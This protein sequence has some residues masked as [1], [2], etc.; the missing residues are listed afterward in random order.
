MRF[1]E[2]TQ[3]RCDMN[4][5]KQSLM[6]LLKVLENAVL[7]AQPTGQYIGLT[8]GD[9]VQIQSHA[10]IISDALE[11]CLKSQEHQNATE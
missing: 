8:A 7:I 4:D 3:G 11:S 6:F 10:K 5:P 2:T 1:H 9:R